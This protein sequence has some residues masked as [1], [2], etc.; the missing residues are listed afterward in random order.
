MN[1]DF[2]KS[3]PP[4]SGVGFLFQ[5]PQNK[6]SIAVKCHVSQDFVRFFTLP[7]DEWKYS[8]LIG[9]IREF[10]PYFNGLVSA[11]GIL[12]FTSIRNIKAYTNA[13]K[14]FL[15]FINRYKN[16]SIINN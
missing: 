16:N 15:N 1:R 10:H 2:L 5:Q 4:N 8:A 3:N 14:I 7:R 13:S 6:P 11:N 9:R 12:T